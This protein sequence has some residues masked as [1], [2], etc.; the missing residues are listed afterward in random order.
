MSAR[1][2]ALS[3]V[4]LGA[5]FALNCSVSDGPVEGS[6]GDGGASTTTSN[7]GAGGGGA[8][9]SNLEQCEAMCV[10]MFLDGE[11]DYRLLRECLLCG[12]C[13]DACV[14]VSESVCVN[15]TTEVGACSAMA[16][17]DCDACVA[18][19]CA[20]MQMQDTTFTGLCAPFGA[21]CSA[22]TNCLQINNC[23]ADCVSPTTTG[24]TTGPGGGMMGAGGN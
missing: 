22:N 13:A 1:F 4:I 17:G 3:S 21:A 2:I 24:P 16:G 12:A 15:G 19:P 10:P 23:V 20:L 7:G 8:N 14:D 9:G 11:A 6:G 18:G 5:A